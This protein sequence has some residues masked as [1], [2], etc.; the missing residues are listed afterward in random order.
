M[1]FVEKGFGNPEKLK[2][3]LNKMNKETHIDDFSPSLALIYH[4]GELNSKG[5]Y[6]LYECNEELFRAMN[7][8]KEYPKAVYGCPAAKLSDDL[9]ER[10]RSKD[11]V[12]I[13]KY[14]NSILFLDENARSMLASKIGIVGKFFYRRDL[15]ADV[16]LADCLRKASIKKPLKMVYRHRGNAGIIVSFFNGAIDV[17]DLTTIP[18]FNNDKYGL[19]YWEVTDYNTIIEFEGTE[20]RGFVPVIRISQSDTGNG[21]FKREF[22]MRNKGSQRTVVIGHEAEWN[23][24]IH[25][26]MG[27]VIKNPKKYLK[28]WIQPSIGK[29][30]TEEVLEMFDDSTE[31]EILH[32]ALT[33][34]D[35]VGSI[36]DTSDRALSVALGN[37]VKNGIV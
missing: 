7:S 28:K 14:G 35:L 22:A 20:E 18:E 12:T 15:I 11:I 3:V 21:L 37:L 25:R 8:L 9:N 19:G 5:L 6:P 31:E 1:S 36:N 17:V 4:I 13:I 33:I 27:S 32:L 30:R 34:P 26:D 2:N 16:V 23:K 10:I 29:K 24:I